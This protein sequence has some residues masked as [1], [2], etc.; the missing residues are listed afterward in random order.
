[1]PIALPIALVAGSAIAGGAELYGAHK[2]AQ[3]A[4]DA[5]NTQKDYNDKALA[6]AQESQAYQRNAYNQY[7]NRLQPYTQAYSGSMSKLA[8]LLGQ[9]QP[10][11]GAMSAQMPAAS[12]AMVTLR[13]PNGMTKQVPSSQAQHYISRGATQV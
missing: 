6:A 3:A 11:A 10:T 1:M 12:S 5:A 2:Q 7:L 4:E 13:A 8:S 9:T